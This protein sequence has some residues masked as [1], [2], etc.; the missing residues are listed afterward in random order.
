MAARMRWSRPRRGRSRGTGGQAR[1]VGG[2]DLPNERLGDGGRAQIRERGAHAR[3]EGGVGCLGRGLDRTADLVIAIAEGAQPL[4]EI[5]I[6]FLA[7][8]S[9]LGRIAARL[10]PLA[11]HELLAEGALG[12][13]QIVLA[14]AKANV[15]DGGLASTRELEDVVELEAGARLTAASVCADE[16]ALPA[17]ALDDAA[18]DVGRDVARIMARY[19]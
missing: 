5:A 17:V 15:V 19:V 9:C 11:E 8:R 16:R 3:F 10:F 12:R 6:A 13:V 1:I 4:D 7:L 14:T 2:W 18:S